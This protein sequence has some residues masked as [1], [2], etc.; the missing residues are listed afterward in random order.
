MKYA[1]TLDGKIAAYTGLSKWITGEAARNHV[2]QQRHRY[3]AIMAGIGTVLADNPL[4]TCR[5]PGCKNPVRIICDT[6]LRIPLT[7]QIVTTA[8]EVTTVIASCSPD[9]EKKEALEQAGCRVLHTD[10]KN[11]HVDLQQLMTMLGAEQVDSILLEGGGTLNW[12][13]LESGIVQKVQAYAAPKLF[14]GSTAKTPVEGTGVTSP[15]DAFILKDS[16]I[17]KLGEDFLIEGTVTGTEAGEMCAKTTAAEADCAEGC[18][19]K[20]IS[21]KG[22][23]TEDLAAESI[24]KERLSEEGITAQKENGGNS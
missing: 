23:A 14:G 18:L 2:Q 19:A 24:L 21:A 13:A 4:L 11:G 7:S 22:S 9:S 1:M 8:D 3:T 12:A 10:K 6:N 20:E 5:I 15:A 16:T 17:I